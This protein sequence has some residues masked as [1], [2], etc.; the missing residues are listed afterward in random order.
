VAAAP[1]W[2]IDSLL[3]QLTEAELGAAGAEGR[4]LSAW[5]LQ[6]G[7]ILTATDAGYL[8]RWSSSARFLGHVRSNT[9]T[10]S[11]FGALQ[12][13]HRRG[14]D[15]LLLGDPTLRSV[16]SV[17]AATGAT[18][19]LRE[20]DGID[21]AVLFSATRSGTTFLARAPLK[22]L[23]RQ[24]DTPGFHQDTR[25]LVRLRQG[26][27]AIDTLTP[28]PA[29]WWERRGTRLISIPLSG[30]I[31]SAVG[32]QGFV[33]GHGDEFRVRW[34]G[35]DGEMQE[36]T[37]I[38]LPRRRLAEEERQAFERAYRQSLEGRAEGLDTLRYREW[39]PI[40]MAARLDRQG[41]VWVQ[42]W[43]AGRAE[44]RDWIV[45]SR[46]GQAIARATIPA[47]LTPTEIG[48]NY[49]LGLS[50]N[51]GEERRVEMWRLPRLQGRQ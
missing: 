10:Q 15:S 46:V 31:W 49:V 28:L 18:E 8:S 41:L 11:P 44:A 42:L 33:V 35:V 2:A 16:L 14:G 36:T 27:G 37:A 13:V 23:I 51:P 40:T 3:L 39:A 12:F 26:G 4:L 24:W 32:A 48:D 30:A 43:R 34:F 17:D 1:E 50:G 29:N 21:G 7:D 19:M 25:Y 5:R 45:V 20:G 22:A 47:H 6:S 38:D 9:D